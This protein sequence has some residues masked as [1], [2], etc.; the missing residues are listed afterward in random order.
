SGYLFA[1]TEKSLYIFSLSHPDELSF[2]NELKTFEF[3]SKSW[4]KDGYIFLGYSDGLIKAL[5]AQLPSNIYTASET[6]IDTATISA[7]FYDDLLYLTT[8]NGNLFTLDISSLWSVIVIDSIYLSPPLYSLKRAGSNLFV[9][10]GDKGIYVLSLA[11]P[12]HPAIIDTIHTPDSVFAIASRDSILLAA[13]GANGLIIYNIRDLSDP[14][15]L[16]SLPGDGYSFEIELY[17]SYAFIGVRDYGI[18]VVD[19][20]IPTAPYEISRYLHEISNFVFSLFYPLLYIG[21]STGKL[22]CLDIS[23]PTRMRPVGEY[24]FG[25]P[26]LHLTSDSN[27]CYVNVYKSG[28]SVMKFTGSVA[29][30]TFSIRF[31]RGWNMI[32]LPVNAHVAVRDS[33][34]FIT[35]PV[36]TYDNTSRRYVV[37][38]TLYPGKGY[39]F[40]SF[41]DTVRSIGGLPLN[42]Y[43]IE[44]NPGW[45]MVGALGINLPVSVYTENSFVIPPVYSF[46]GGRYIVA[47]SLET[48]KSYWVLSRERATIEISSGK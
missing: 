2:V 21:D 26:I 43:T 16:A 1:I 36:Y 20:S 35:T 4:V 3:S 30:T 37:I 15:L 31:S 28:V 7:I 8:E 46:S 25:S 22:I 44:I 9:A 11:N 39:W 19:I 18:K 42:S 47:D 34:A 10:G 5:N 6:M 48:G 38:D 41:V 13:C 24:D 14:E 17:S 12:E 45:N 23:D 29:P 40:L 27:F 32:S 33:F